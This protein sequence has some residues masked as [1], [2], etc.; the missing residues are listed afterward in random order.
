[1]QEAELVDRLKNRDEK[2][3][4][5]MVE[6][7]GDMLYRYADRMCGSVEQAED[8]LQET[9]LTAL[10]KIYQFRG[11]G[12]LRNW[13][14]RIA[15]NKCHQSFRNQSASKQVQLEEQE[16]MMSIEP[17]SPLGDQPW[18]LDPG[19]SLL[20]EELHEFL[21]DAIR[22]IAPTNRSVLIMR[23]LE[24]LNTRETSE[25]LGITE[26]TVKVRLHRARIHVRNQLK[27]YMEEKS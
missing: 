11:E 16:S 19:E 15:S 10:E 13:L 23:D 3:F 8:V 17:G 27:N 14:F 1:M 18:Y 20:T 22:G 21:E 12:K 24:G 7:Y 6:R 2:A 25:V 5:D 9:F 26:E 4:E